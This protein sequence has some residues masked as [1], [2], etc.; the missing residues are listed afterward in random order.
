MKAD[1]VPNELLKVREQIDEIDERLLRLLAERFQLTHQVGIVKASQALASFDSTREAE[2]LERL[3]ALCGD[4]QLDPAL[5][6]ELF[7]R[8][9]QEVVKNHDKLRQQ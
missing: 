6:T 7:T 1:T 9:M 5:V 8:I 2:K 3:R 4:L